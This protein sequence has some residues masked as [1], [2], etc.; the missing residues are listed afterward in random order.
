TLRKRKDL[1][2]IHFELNHM[3]YFARMKYHFVNRRADAFLAILLTDL[4]F[5]QKTFLADV[6]A[7]QH[8]G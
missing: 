8:I 3:R 4:R 1:V 2:D 6:V 5:Q 7:F